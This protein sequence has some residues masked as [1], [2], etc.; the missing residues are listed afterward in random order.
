MQIFERERGEH[1]IFCLRK[2][3]SSWAE[4]GVEAIAVT[5]GIFLT[6]GG[7][8]SA[9]AAGGRE[10]KHWLNLQTLPYHLILLL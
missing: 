3:K 7:C 2:R 8:K 1:N 5:A 9:L 6:K 4:C 10:S